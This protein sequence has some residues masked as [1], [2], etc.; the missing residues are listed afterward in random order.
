MLSSLFIDC[1]YFSNE[2]VPNY[3]SCD[4]PTK[5]SNCSSI[6]FFRKDDI[7]IFIALEKYAEK[8]QPKTSEIS[9]FADLTEKLLIDQLSDLEKVFF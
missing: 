4:I 7:G 9:A 3:F 6:L 8:M 5:A 1:Q 2:Q